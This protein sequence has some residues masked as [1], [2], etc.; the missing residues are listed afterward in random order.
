MVLSSIC[1][2]FT[3]DNWDLQFFHGFVKIKMLQID[4]YFI[5]YRIA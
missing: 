4:V 3:Q 5:E 1:L 2:L